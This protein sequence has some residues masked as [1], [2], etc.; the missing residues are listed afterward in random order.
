MANRRAHGRGRLARAGRSWNPIAGLAVVAVTVAA[1]IAAITI[2]LVVDP[3]GEPP[4]PPKAAIV[5]HLS[6]TF[7]NEDF[8][9]NATATLEQ[10]GYIVDYFPGEEVTVEFYQQLPTHGYDVVVFRVH[11]DRLQAT[12]QGREIDEV[13]LFTGELYSEEKYLDDRAAARLTI[14]RYHAGGERYFGI[15][16]DFIDDRMDGRFDGTKIIMM[17]CEGLLSERTAEAFVDKGAS[18]YI[19]WDETVSASHTDAASEL[20]LEHLLLDG[21]SAQE[22]VAQTMAEIGPDPTYGSKLLAYPSEG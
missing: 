17:G 8:I 18:T 4:G 6:L 15:A 13:I 20:L 9:Q 22:A 10:A 1:V 12:L 7:P 2:W 14:A 16:P 11:A 19:S 21:L 5:D 3:L